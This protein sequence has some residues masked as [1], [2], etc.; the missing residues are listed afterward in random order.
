MSNN[1]TSGLWLKVL[2]QGWMALFLV[3]VTAFLVSKW[4]DVSEVYY[5]LQSPFF[6]VA[7]TLL[8]MAVIFSAILS[9]RLLVKYLLQYE[10]EMGHAL[11][12]FIL[13]NLGKYLPGKAWGMLARG[14]ELV[15]RGASTNTVVYA[16][17]LEQYV[18]LVSAV[19][20]AAGAATY[21][22]AG[23]PWAVLL[24]LIVQGAGLWLQ[25]NVLALWLRWR[26]NDAK[27]TGSLDASKY[28]LLAVITSAGWVFNGLVVYLIATQSF[29]TTMST[30]MM[31]MLVAANA[32]AV[33]AGFIAL[34]APAGIG[35]RE[36]VLAWILL[37]WLSLTDSLALAIAHRAW[38]V[39]WDVLF[40]TLLLL[41]A[42]QRLLGRDSRSSSRKSEADGDRFS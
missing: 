5:L 32:I 27:S 26:R 14:G 42:I 16:T 36:G 23:V 18:L 33:S 6:L 41:P 2:R 38:L 25:R 19:A 1:A 22:F 40:V 30:D 39:L 15:E 10:L 13:L 17:L 28:A 35:V 7:G 11:R 9:W 20:V 31:P 3:G 37:P 8:Q 24:F 12:H 34:F 21:M 4:G 29:G